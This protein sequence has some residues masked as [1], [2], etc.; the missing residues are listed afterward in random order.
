MVTGEVT[1]LAFARAAGF[2]LVKRKARR[3]LQRDC[4]SE[5]EDENSEQA[6]RQMFQRGSEE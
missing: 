3:C 6:G 5:S 2:E 4:M 1:E